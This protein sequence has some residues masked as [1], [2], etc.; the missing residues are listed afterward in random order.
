MQI[1]EADVN[2]KEEDVLHDRLHQLYEE[3]ARVKFKLDESEGSLSVFQANLDGLKMGMLSNIFIFIATLLMTMAFCMLPMG[4]FSVVK[5]FFLM[6]AIPMIAKTFFNA[7]QSI[8]QVIYNSD[9]VYENLYRKE[10]A[11][12][13]YKIDHEKE[14]I[15][16]L[17][18]EIKR[19]EEEIG[20]VKLELY[21]DNL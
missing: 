18:Q 9:S 6:F 20:Q 8:V 10:K 15:K 2:L 19:I 13:R 3:L 7:M 11:I 16:Q 12:Y 14:Q 1:K 21:D 17:E 5:I 4:P